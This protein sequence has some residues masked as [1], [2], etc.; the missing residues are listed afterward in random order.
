VRPATK[1][2]DWR[3]RGLSVTIPHKLAV[4]PH[5]DF[6]DA[7]AQAVGAVNTIIVAGAELHG[8]NTDATGAMK[9]LDELLDVRSARVAVLGAGGAAR[10]VCYG[11]RERGAAVTIFARD[12]N[13]AQPLAEEF[14]AR[15]ARLKS[16]T[17]Q[18]DVV[19][20]CTPSGM[21]GHSEGEIPL[22]AESLREVKLVYDLV[23]NPEETA[24]LQA[25]RQA[26]C[27][28]LGGLAMLAAQA[29]E[30]FRLFTGLAAPI[31]VMQR[32]ARGPG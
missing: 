23:Y 7:A 14:G 13:K 6:I 24:L 11:L 8:Y 27:Q 2:L 32:A 5:L 25:A 20:N 1:R 26:G 18:T 28:T 19:I 4:M 15:T 9:P 10:A 12:I 31:E 17:G 16:F 30:Q 22:A 21:K 3:L 29:A